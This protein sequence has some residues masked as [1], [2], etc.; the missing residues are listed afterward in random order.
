MAKS[1]EGKI[2][3]NLSGNQNYF[4]LNWVSTWDTGL[5]NGQ[6]SVDRKSV[7]MGTLEW[8]SCFG[9]WFG[10]R[11]SCLPCVVVQGK[12]YIVDKNEILLFSGL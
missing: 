5:S 7:F 10:H 11:K 3:Q 12:K 4:D 1:K 9:L 2:G 8:K 6:N